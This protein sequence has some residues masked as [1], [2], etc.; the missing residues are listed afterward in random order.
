MNNNIDIVFNSNFEQVNNLKG[1]KITSKKED[2]SS[3]LTEEFFKT[4]I[5]T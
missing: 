2:N 5:K 3:M 4:F 1:P